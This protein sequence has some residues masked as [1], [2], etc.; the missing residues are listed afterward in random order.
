MT[1]HIQPQRHK[2]MVKCDGGN[3]DDNENDN[4]NTYDQQ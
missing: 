4:D 3:D 2:N 1:V